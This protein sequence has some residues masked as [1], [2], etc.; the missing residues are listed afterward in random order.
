MAKAGAASKQRSGGWYGTES[1]E[2]K[3]FGLALDSRHSVKGFVS[4]GRRMDVF[5]R[6]FTD[7]NYPSFFATT[8]VHVPR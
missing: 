6:N 1:G 7:R 4:Q 3:S 2:V 8:Q 5:D